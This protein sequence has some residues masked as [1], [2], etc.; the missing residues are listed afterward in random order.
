[1][2]QIKAHLNY[3][4]ISPRKVRLVANLIKGKEIKTAENLLRS[5]TKRST[6]FL[7]KLLNSAIANAKHNFQI[8]KDSLF[9]KNVLVNKG[10]TLK[11]FLPRARG[12]ASR[13]NKRSSHITVILNTKN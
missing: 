4:R 11:R 1:M 5:A 2:K 7:Q 9:I 12:S 8:D 6:H 10:P 13:I 3:L